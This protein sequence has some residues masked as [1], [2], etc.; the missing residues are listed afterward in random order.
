M[1]RKLA[2]TF[3]SCICFA[4]LNA[5]AR[6]F[7]FG[8]ESFAAYVGGAWSPGFEN[9]LNSQS[10]STSSVPVTI[11]SKHPYNLDGEFG[12]IY[13]KA[14]VSLRFGLEVLRPKD[15]NEE[16]ATSNGLEVYSLTSEI[17]VWVPKVAIEVTAKQWPT[18]RLFFE[19][20][21]GY[22]SLAARNSYDLTDAGDSAYGGLTDFYEDLRSYTPMFEGSV[23]YETL[24][25]DS[26]TVVFHAGY[27]RMNFD[28]IK[29]NRDV[30]TFGGPVSKGDAAVNADGTKRTLN[31]SN[32]F[33]GASL[34]FWIP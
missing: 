34:R 28:D 31:L 22:A 12:F 7:N 27:R 26:T 16:K 19:A 10:N 9:T 11:N 24:F 25:T 15:I 5:Q 32:Y 29:H 14:G 1:T 6:V 20:G 13:T 21:T 4:A 33:V 3:L 2:L 30:T 17:S 23:G 8:N 18:A